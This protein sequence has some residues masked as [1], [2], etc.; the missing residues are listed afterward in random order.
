MAAAFCLS[1]PL[2][3]LTLPI[4]SPCFIAVVAGNS[5]IP[6]GI[7]PFDD[8]IICGDDG[9]THIVAVYIFRGTQ[10]C[11]NFIFAHTFAG[12]LMKAGFTVR[13]NFTQVLFVA[14]TKIIA[15][16]IHKFGFF[17]DATFCVSNLFHVAAI[18]RP[19]SKQLR[20]QAY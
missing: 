8:G 13:E 6:A 5:V 20:L 7:L 15:Q 4:V 18:W 14:M 3:R 17:H 1:L 9:F 16:E 19:C 2:F 11:A 12:T 10:L